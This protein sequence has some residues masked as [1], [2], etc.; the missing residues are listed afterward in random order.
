MSIPAGFF[1]EPI[2][3]L[4]DPKHSGSPVVD[5]INQARALLPQIKN[6]GTVA[7]KRHRVC[8]ELDVLLKRAL[9]ELK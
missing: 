6:Y 4:A 8:D 1:D 5:A 2:R 3:H 7:G 9:D